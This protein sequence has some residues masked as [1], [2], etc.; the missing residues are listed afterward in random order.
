MYL[1][2]VSVKREERGPTRHLVVCA[3]CAVWGGAAIDNMAGSLPLEFKSS[4]R[5]EIEGRE[6]ER[7]ERSRPGDAIR[8]HF[9]MRAR[10]KEG[11]ERKG[12]RPRERRSE[13]VCIVA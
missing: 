2:V 13:D 9:A 1:S 6:K 3:K 4:H 11:V 8:A 10:D 12:S 7:G 5:K